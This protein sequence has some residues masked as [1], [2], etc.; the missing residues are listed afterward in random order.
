MTTSYDPPPPALELVPDTGRYGVAIG[1]HEGRLRAVEKCQI[2]TSRDVAIGKWLMGI[3]LVAVLGSGVGGIYSA[4]QTTERVE[5]LVE[6]VR[7]AT[8]LREAHGSEVDRL[9]DTTRED[10]S[11]IRAG[12]S[13]L[14]A[15][16]SANAETAK[17]RHNAIQGELSGIRAQLRRVRD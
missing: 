5:T 8:R 7:E 1:D 9:R 15:T 12:V 4:G 17:T 11:Q 10:I 3:I 14:E 16:V 6:G 2:K 13:G